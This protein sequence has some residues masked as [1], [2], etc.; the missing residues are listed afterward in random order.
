MLKN[1]ITLWRDTNYEI[2]VDTN[3]KLI[4]VVDGIGQA[5]G[6]G[7]TYNV[8]EAL[9]VVEMVKSVSKIMCF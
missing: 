1:P 7:S 2:R 3:D 8:P 9:A 6:R 5:D 4:N